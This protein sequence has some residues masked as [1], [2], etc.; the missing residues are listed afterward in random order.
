[1]F[2]ADECAPVGGLTRESKY[3]LTCTRISCMVSSSFF[4]MSASDFLSWQLL[5]AETQP[6]ALIENSTECT[7]LHFEHGNAD[8][9]YIAHAPFRHSFIPARVWLG[10]RLV[11][12][13]PSPAFIPTRVWLGTKLINQVPSPA[14]IPAR[15]WRGTRLV[16][17]VPSPESR[18]DTMLVY[19]GL[20]PRLWQMWIGFGT[21][22]C[23][24]RFANRLWYSQMHYKFCKCFK[25]CEHAYE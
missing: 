22:E 25:I 15:V 1:M 20:V 13:V 17:L 9:P 2:C 14:F 6:S 12:Q 10:T 18:N 16:N 8:M 3:S 21:C 24:V 23:A 7:C 5:L 4:T 19:A 11:N